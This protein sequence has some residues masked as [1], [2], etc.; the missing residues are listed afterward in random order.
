MLMDSQIWVILGVL[1]TAVSSIAAVLTM[2]LTM[3]RNKKDDDIKHEKR[4]QDSESRVLI[5]ETEFKSFKTL[6]ASKL[7][8]IN[9]NLDELKETLKEKI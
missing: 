4:H 9:K 1:I 5:L 3:S 8:N 2:A 6:I 7:D